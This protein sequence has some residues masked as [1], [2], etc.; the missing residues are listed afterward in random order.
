MAPKFKLGIDA[1]FMMEFDPRYT[2]KYPIM[3]EKTG[4][5]HLW[6]GDH[7]L[8]WQAS[9]QESFFVWELLAVVASKTKKIKLG[10]DVTVPIGARYHPAIIAQA[11]GTL[12]RMFPGR[13]VLGVGSGEA[14][15][16]SWFWGHWPK[17]SERMD[18]LIEG[19]ELIKRLW[20]EDDYFRFDGKYFKMGVTKLYV[21]PKKAVPI[22]MSATGRKS[23]YR[24]G[25]HADRLISSGNPQAMQEVVFP[26]FD[27]GARAVGRDPSKMEKAVLMDMATGSE[28]K[29]LARIKRLAAG[30][31]IP[32]MFNEGDPR[33]IERAGSKLPKEHLL[34]NIVLFKKPD[35]VIEAVDTFRKL[36]ATQVIISEMSVEPDFAMKVYSKV[37]EYFKQEA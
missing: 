24:A 3:A 15:N 8:P 20:A 25:R 5:D 35:Q 7:Y 23:A 18:R 33:V 19:V 16:E 6:M 34:K 27:R 1:S 14:L 11:V 12:E 9:F 32:E 29:I 10:P 17:W 37:C 13:F 30:S 26:N 31:T 28:D 36:G 4:F 2:L 22:Y 21:K